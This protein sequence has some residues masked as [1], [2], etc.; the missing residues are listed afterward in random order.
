MTAA[1]YQP[2]ES[3]RAGHPNVFFKKIGLDSGTR[4]HGVPHPLDNYFD[5]PFVP[6]F[7][8]CLRTFAAA[9]DAFFARATRSARVIVSRLRFPPFAPIWAI[10][11]RMRLRD[12]V[13]IQ[14]SYILTA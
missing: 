9:R 11:F 5:I 12:N 7:F 8:R 14:R 13:S 6:T 3:I 1:S 2:A 4:T 10:A